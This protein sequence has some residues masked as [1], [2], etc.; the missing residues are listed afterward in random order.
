MRGTVALVIIRDD[1][2]RN[3][4][5]PPSRAQPPLDQTIEH[6]RDHDDVGGA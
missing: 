1:V 5:Q 4:A 6:R 3:H 2:A